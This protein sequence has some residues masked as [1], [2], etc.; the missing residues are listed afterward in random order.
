ML[1]VSAYLCI[2]VYEYMYICVLML[3]LS[4]NLYLTCIYVHRQ[5]C[6]LLRLDK[7]PVYVA[8]APNNTNTPNKSI[9]SSITS[10]GG[11]N[12]TN[13]PNS[14]ATSGSGSGTNDTPSSTTKRLS[15]ALQS[16]GLL[17]GGNSASTTAAAANSTGAPPVAL[18]MSEVSDIITSSTCDCN[19]GGVFVIGKCVCVC[20]C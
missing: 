9:R 3:R 10:S 20:V 19:G 16:V 11:N 4:H 7:E 1:Q 5:I 8:A 12:N 6:D 17:S 15:M 14:K 18:D 2:C 13:T